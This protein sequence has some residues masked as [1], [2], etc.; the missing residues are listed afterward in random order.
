METKKMNLGFPK[1]L[2]ITFGFAMLASQLLVA[3]SNG[4]G[5]GN[6]AVPVAP[7]VGACQ[8]AVNGQTLVVAPSIS[9]LQGEWILSGDANLIQQQ[10]MMNPVAN[11]HNIYQGPL[12]LSGTIVAS[13]LAAFSGSCYQLQNMNGAGFSFN[14]I[15]PGMAYYG[16]FE[17]PQ[18]QASSAA[19]TFT[20]EVHN[21][22][23]YNGKF[24]A[25]LLVTSVN[26]MQC[27]S[28]PISVF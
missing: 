11:I 9:P 23:L 12:M 24:S 14:T 5:G 2:L 3:C 27:R 18:V 13:N 28:F 26:G 21:G 20:F 10:R 7:C 6:N 1:K 15:T 4:G 8:Q 19:G 22:M 25:E 16:T 17:V